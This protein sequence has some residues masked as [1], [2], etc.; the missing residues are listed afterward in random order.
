MQVAAASKPLAK[1]HPWKQQPGVVRQSSIGA[2]GP[3]YDGGVTGQGHSTRS[4]GS[5]PAT[6]SG[7]NGGVSI[8]VEIPEPLAGRLAEE[9]ARRGVDPTDLAVEALTEAYGESDP[10]ESFIGCGSSGTSE[11]LDIHAMRAELAARK[12]AEGAQINNASRPSD[13]HRSLSRYRRLRRTNP[14]RMCPEGAER[15]HSR[16]SR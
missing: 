2:L 4:G 1:R 14:H 8:T 7:D 9:T 15:R 16:P 12:L 10:L 3:R 11:P 6:E 13:R 5:A